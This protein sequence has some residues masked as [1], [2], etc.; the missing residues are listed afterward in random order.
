MSYSRCT[1]VTA[2]IM[3]I[4]SRINQQYTWY[5][6]VY[7][8]A[9]VHNP[10]VTLQRRQAY[11]IGRWKCAHTFAIMRCMYCTNSRQKLVC[12]D[13]MTHFPER[14]QTLTG[15]DGGDQINQIFVIYGGVTDECDPL[16]PPL[17]EKER[18]LPNCHLVHPM[19]YNPSSGGGEYMRP[20]M[21]RCIH[22]PLLQEHDRKGLSCHNSA[23]F[24]VFPWIP[25]KRTRHPHFTL[26][27]SWF[28]SYV[29]WFAGLFCHSPSAAQT[30]EL[31]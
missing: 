24:K 20:S 11:S 13:F 10:W 7:S 19:T 14:R 28:D 6:T 30:G 27:S 22:S 25:S 1:F 17:P 21:R 8:S 5:C 12:T 4:I 16:P 26:R 18:W 23:S 29:S 3:H 15:F 31:L 2:V 9:I